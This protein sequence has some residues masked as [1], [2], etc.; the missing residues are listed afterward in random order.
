MAYPRIS[1]AAPGTED[2]E[3]CPPPVPSYGIP[4]RWGPTPGF[5]VAV[6]PR[7]CRRTAVGARSYGQAALASRIRLPETEPGRLA[8]VALADVLVEE[9]DGPPPGQL[10]RRQAAGLR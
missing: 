5:R 4:I 2:W 3:K 10:G 7:R 9:R 1:C 6:S 8:E